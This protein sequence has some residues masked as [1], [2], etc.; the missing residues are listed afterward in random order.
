MFPMMGAHRNQ[1]R[2]EEECQQR[3]REGLDDI[4]QKIDELA[5]KRIPKSK[6]SR[7]LG[8]PRKIVDEYHPE[9]FTS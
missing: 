3:E 9:R 2:M 6:I 1:Q 4:I 5:K 7:M 8:V